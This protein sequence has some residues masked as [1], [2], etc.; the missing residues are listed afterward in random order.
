M[1]PEF[2]PEVPTLS[3]SAIDPLEALLTIQ[4]AAA[5]MQVTADWLN[6]LRKRGI[7]PQYIRTSRRFIRYRRADIEAWLLLHTHSNA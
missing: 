6:I 1:L 3:S 5:Y 4:E 7:G 2:C